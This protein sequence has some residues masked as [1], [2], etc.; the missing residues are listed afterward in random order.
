MLEVYRG[1]LCGKKG[2]KEP[3]K[4]SSRE[5]CFLIFKELNI[6]I[7]LILNTYYFIGGG[8]KSPRYVNRSLLC[9]TYFSLIYKCDGSTWSFEIQDRKLMVIVLEKMHDRKVANKVVNSIS[10]HNIIKVKLFNRELRL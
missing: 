7:L 5:L 4:Y 9:A 2:S 6:F 1:S 10:R 8:L 3:Y